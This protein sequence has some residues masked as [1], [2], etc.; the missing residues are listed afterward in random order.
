MTHLYEAPGAVSL[1]DRKQNGGARDWG[2]EFVF[3]GDRVSDL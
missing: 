2:G 1:V 3:R